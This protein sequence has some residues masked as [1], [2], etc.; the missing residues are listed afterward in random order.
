MTT[1]NN[2]DG[3]SP[4]FAQGSQDFYERLLLKSNSAVVITNYLVL[5]NPI[6]YVNPA[7]EAI[8]GYKNEELKG[9]NCRFL[10]SDDRDQDCI[11]QIS[12]SIKTGNSCECVLRNYRK[13]GTLFYNKLHLFPICNNAGTVTHYAGILHDVTD[14]VQSIT[15]LEEKRKVIEHSI[16]AYIKVSPKGIVIEANKAV[17]SALGWKPES[18]CGQDLFALLGHTIS[19]D[20]RKDLLHQVPSGYKTIQFRKRDGSDAVLECA[21]FKAGTDH[22]IIYLVRDIT[23]RIEIER[24]IKHARE[25][26][27]SI[28]N[29]ISEGCF[30]FDHKLKLTFINHAAEKILDWQGKDAIGNDLR[31]IFSEK[32]DSTFF[33]AFSSAL[34]EKQHTSCVEYHST[35][36]KW[37]Q[38]RVYPLDDGLTVFLRDVTQ[39]KLD[40]ERLLHM[41]HND[42]LTGIANRSRYISILQSQLA[43][44]KNKD[45]IAVLFI[46]LDRFK[47]VNDAFGHHIGDAVLVTVAHRLRALENGKRFVGR[48]SGDEFAFTLS[49]TTRSEAEAFAQQIIAVISKPVERDGLEVSIGASIGIALSG[50]NNQRADDLMGQADSAMYAAKDAGRHTFTVYSSAMEAQQRRRLQLRLEIRSAIAAG[51]FRLL[52]QP[53]INLREKRLKGAEALIRWQHPQLGLLTPNVFLQIAEESAL[54]ID[55]GNWV[56]D[57]ACRQVAIWKSRGLSLIVSVNLSSRQLMDS[58]LPDFISETV[59]KHHIEP[60]HIKIEITESMVMQDFDKATDNLLSLRARGFPIALDDFGAGYSNL[61]YLSRFPVTTLKIDRSFVKGLGTDERA[62]KLLTAVVALAKSLDLHVVCKGIENDLQ[63]QALETTSC[64]AAQGY[65]FGYPLHPDEFF[66]KFDPQ[67]SQRK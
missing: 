30:S 27:R 23:E 63:L 26:S 3:R 65:L 40:Q 56:I 54:I 50:K 61:G 45:E 10:Q 8:S 38:A 7:F 13:D 18:L 12:T 46:D 2:S 47:E 53:Q 9:K 58:N 48:I 60:M 6:V 32:R 4:L 35:L 34:A 25:R 19:G 14:A 51:E 5:D 1:N 15:V 41:A 22:D 21:V 64:D 24:E 16:D 11:P 59:N 29:S 36:D 17:E 31:L 44:A 49:R 37:I 62:L 55:M 33:N 52:Y 67:T 28:L 42:A 39:E 20:L 57:E 66:E 43:L